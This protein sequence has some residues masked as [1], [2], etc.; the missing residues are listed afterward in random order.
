MADEASLDQRQTLLG[1]Y[2]I[3]PDAD[4]ASIASWPQNKEVALFILN[5]PIPDSGCKVF[6]SVWSRS[7]YRVCVD[8]GG[9]R[10]YDFCKDQGALDKFVPD[11]IV[12]D[13]DSIQET[14]RAF[15]EKKGSR[16]HFYDDQESTDFM[17][18]F[19]YLDSEMRHGK[20][21]NDCVVIVFGGLGGRLDHVMH[22]LKVLFN[23]HLKRQMYVI[24]ESNLTFVI[25]SGKN[26]ILVNKQVD[27]PKCGI[28]PLAGQTMLTTRGLRWNLT[29]HSSSFEG[30][31]STSNII[32]DPEI[33]IETTLPVAW[34]CEFNP[35][36]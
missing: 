6:E 27:G 8:G 17:K 31:M 21:P 5:E 29:N 15:Y 35:S 19:M 14:T 18:G 9:N 20:D 36:G 28:L 34:T 13:L 22:T 12:G 30:L 7:N 3:Y 10:L 33:Y 25:P 2:I 23:N 4:S 24:S 16:I 11:V 1:S 26:R 32:D